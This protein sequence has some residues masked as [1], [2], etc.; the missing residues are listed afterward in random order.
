MRK[1]FS[2]ILVSIVLTSVQ[3]K[4]HNLTF[5]LQKGKE[6]RQVIKSKATII[7][8]VNG[9]L[10]NMVMTI[11]G[12]V[13]FFVVSV[14][15][16][17]YDLNVKYESLGMSMEMP[18]GKAEFSSEKADEQDV[19]SIILSKMIGKT[20]KVKMAKDG[21]VIE[22][23][24]IEPMIESLFED[25]SDIPEDQLQQL[26][27]QVNKSYGAEAFRGNVEMVTAIFP[28][29]PVKKG[30]KWTIK[31]NLESGISALMTT[32]YKFTKSTTE[33]AMIEG[34]SVIETADKDAYVESN[35]MPMKYDMTG[36]MISE[37]KVDR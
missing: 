34:V 31:T 35:G 28:E 26:K 9:Q 36:E 24:N 20:F 19:F 11:N 13:S 25:F 7:Q 29:Q 14:N 22:V 27:N 15:P 33:H 21:K 30:E 4:E 5:N 6:Y 32:E 1:I 8:E 37:I 12:G 3:A 18:Q 23:K 10:M 17:D 16:T 2:L